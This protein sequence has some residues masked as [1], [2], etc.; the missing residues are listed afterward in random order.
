MHCF[1]NLMKVL[2]EGIPSQ[3]LPNEQNEVH[4]TMAI[5]DITFTPECKVKG[6]EQR[7]PSTR[8]LSTTTELAFTEQPSTTH[9]I[10]NCSK[11]YCLNGGTCVPR[12][13]DSA[14]C[15]CKPGQT[16]KKC[17]YNLV[18][19]PERSS[20]KTLIFFIIKQYFI[21]KNPNNL[22]ADKTI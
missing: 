17:E 22:N 16:G 8:I 5:D 2:I 1:F 12:G 21:K 15:Q 6:F 7:R 14:I 9:T 19:F 20:R 10:F 4:R 11:T 18:V 13:T 3:S